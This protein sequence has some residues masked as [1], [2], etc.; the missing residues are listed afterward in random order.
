M[1]EDASRV[2]AYLQHF[3]SGPGGTHRAGSGLGGGNEAFRWHHVLNSKPRRKKAFLCDNLLTAS[4][5]LCTGCPLLLS[6]YLIYYYLYLS[7]SIKLISRQPLAVSQEIGANFQG[8]PRMQ[9]WYFMNFL[10]LLLI[11]LIYYTKTLF[12]WTHCWKLKILKIKN[13]EKSSC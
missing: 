1:S 4:L 3:L 13:F 2:I 10:G 5:D 9:L 6:H 8:L 7:I 11:S 12:F